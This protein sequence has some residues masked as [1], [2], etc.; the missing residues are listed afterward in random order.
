M[1]LTNFESSF[2]PCV[3]TTAV[4]RT[5]K[6]LDAKSYDLLDTYDFPSPVLSL[7]LSPQ[8]H[9][10]FLVAGMMEGS[11]YLMDLVSHIVLQKLKDHT[12]YIVKTAW[13]DDGRWVATI[14]YDK[15]VIIYEVVE[16]AIV[17]ENALLDG[18]EPDELAATPRVELVKRHTHTTKT[19]PEAAVFLPGSSH[20]VFSARDDHL[21]HYLR[22]PAASKSDEDF[23]LSS[24]NLNENNDAW[25]S[26]SM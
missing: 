2:T 26:F 15:A 11:L 21:L 10:R 12:K 8:H 19:N 23:S 4:D 20:L 13:S 16:S 22:L 25:V 5:I 1:E 17:E 9:S 3:F 24:I 14:G 7:A 18:E 6:I